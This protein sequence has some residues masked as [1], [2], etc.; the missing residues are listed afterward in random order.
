MLRGVTKVNFHVDDLFTII[1]IHR[2]SCFLQFAISL[3]FSII[4]FNVAHEL[5]GSK[6]CLGALIQHL[7][8]LDEIIPVV[9]L[10]VVFLKKLIL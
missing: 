3:Q 1:S 6:L 8:P 5:L 4:E 9:S 10:V 2:L 7:L